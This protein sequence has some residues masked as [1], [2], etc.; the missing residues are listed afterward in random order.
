MDNQKPPA[1]STVRVVIRPVLVLPE[2]QSE[3]ELEIARRYL[4]TEAQ[5]RVVTTALIKRAGRCFEC[6]KSTSGKE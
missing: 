1:P 5:L 2:P 6:R 3:H 4:P